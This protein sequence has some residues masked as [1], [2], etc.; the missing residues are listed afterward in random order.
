MDQK[1]LQFPLPHRRT[2]RSGQAAQTGMSV[3]TT[4][5][6]SRRGEALHDLVTQM[7]EKDVIE[8]VPYNVLLFTACYS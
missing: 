6:L 7:L 3:V 4:H 1:G 2:G 5:S 8:Q